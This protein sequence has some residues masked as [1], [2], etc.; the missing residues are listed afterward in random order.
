M[1]TSPWDA[2]G[3]AARI[4]KYWYDNTE[5]GTARERDALALSQVLL[6]G[7]ILEVGCGSGRFYESIKGLLTGRD[8]LGIDYSKQMLNIANNRYPEARFIHGNAERLGTIQSDNVVCRHVLQHVPDYKPVMREL[9]RVTRKM[10]FVCSWFFNEDEVN[11][12]EFGYYDSH[13]GKKGVL[14][15]VAS[16]APSASTRWLDGGQ[17]V[18][19]M[20]R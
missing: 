6:P 18:V 9:L 11:L 17:L 5:E 2:N 12:T 19:Y 8:Y 1:K 20:E 15:I 3:L 7:D 13:V 10:L 4:D 16:C 14:D